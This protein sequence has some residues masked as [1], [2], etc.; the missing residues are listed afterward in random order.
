MCMRTQDRPGSP[1]A[2]LHKQRGPAEE[3]SRDAHKRPRITR[4]ASLFIRAGKYKNQHRA[5]ASDPRRGASATES[6]C[7][8]AMA[9]PLSPVGKKEESACL[10]EALAI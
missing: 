1:I 6:D 2:F 4:G 9:P 10:R 3:L 7:T 5:A 8:H